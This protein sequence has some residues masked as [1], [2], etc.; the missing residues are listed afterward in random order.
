MADNPIGNP[1]A[2]GLAGFALTTFLLNVINAG[3]L[4][5][6]SLGMVLGMGI[7]YG[8]LCQLAAGMWDFRRGDTF[9]ATAFSS[10]GAFWMGLALTMILGLWAPVPAAGKAVFLGAW[11]FF[12]LYMMFGALRISRAV[13]L[14]FAS[15]TILF[16]LLAAGQFDATVHTIAG[17]EGLFTAFT[18]WYASM[19]IVLNEKYGRDVLPVGAYKP[20]AAKR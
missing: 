15:L 12:T 13:T 16:F 10:Y 1:G 8:G 14:V 9:G 18:A 5:A 7:F 6:D 19:A 20:R 2:L 17:Y 4:G 3:L 11:G